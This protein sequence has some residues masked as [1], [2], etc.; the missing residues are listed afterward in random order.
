MFAACNA[1]KSIERV[2]VGA[3][4]AHPRPRTNAALGVPCLCQT[5]LAAWEIISGGPERYVGDEAGIFHDARAG[6]FK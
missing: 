6:A 2:F 5:R 1:G 4:V 3:F